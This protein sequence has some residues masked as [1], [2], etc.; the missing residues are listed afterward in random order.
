MKNKKIIIIFIAIIAVMLMNFLN[1]PISSYVLNQKKSTNLQLRKNYSSICKALMSFEIKNV[2]V[3]IIGDS[4]TYAG[5]NLE[6]L[7][8]NFNN[9]VLACATPTISI[10]NLTNLSK[11]IYEKYEPKLL[12]IGLSAFQFMQADEK[13]EKERKYYYNFTTQNESYKFHFDVIKQ[14]ILHYIRPF[15]ET[16][17]AIKQI[18]FLEKIKKNKPIN[19]NDEINK[20]I[21]LIIKKRYNTYSMDKRNNETQINRICKEFKNIKSQ[22]FFIDIPTPNFFKDNLKYNN[23]YRDN[24]GKLSKCFQV[25]NSENIKELSNDI[26]FFDRGAFFLKNKNLKFDVSHMNFAGS[27]IYTNYLI[28]LIS[29]YNIE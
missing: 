6:I 26:Y 27:M 1:S 4:H 24:L 21:N 20:K 10:N 5:V 14:Y 8:K 7:N 19:Y 16:D 9:L 12:I 15:S 18:N 23:L 29:K 28:N 2:D 11:K 3:I 25:Y 17:I 22:I 13:K